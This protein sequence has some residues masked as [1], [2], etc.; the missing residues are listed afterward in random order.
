MSE[1]NCLLTQNGF[2]ESMTQS[3]SASVDGHAMPSTEA[4]IAGLAM[5]STEALIAAFGLCFVC[6]VLGLCFAASRIAR[7]EPSAASVSQPAEALPPPVSFASSVEREQIVASLE[8]LSKLVDHDEFANHFGS[9][10]TKLSER[11]DGVGLRMLRTENDGNC[12][13]AALAFQ[14]F[15]SPAHH[16]VVRRA[17]V[18][19]MRARREF[20]GLYFE[21]PAALDAYLS[22]IAADKAWG[23]ELTIR[24]AVEAYGCDAHVVTS[25]ANGWYLRYAPEEPRS[26]AD[27]GKGHDAAL[28][29]AFAPKGFLTPPAGFEIFLSYVVPNHYNAVALQLWGQF[30]ET[31]WQES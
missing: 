17:A 28:P 16:A 3:W 23:D 10:T 6:V 15:G 20:F 1:A 9:A 13:F 2:F 22:R 12:Q 31:S 24:A 19:H 5:P 4:L 26:V 18:A 11:L 29:H 8:R 7:G 27:T 30:E 25:E 21:S 14:L